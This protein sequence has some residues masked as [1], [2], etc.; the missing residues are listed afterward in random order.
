MILLVLRVER[1]AYVRQAGQ[2]RLHDGQRFGRI[3]R[4][5]RCVIS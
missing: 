5:N 2:Q 3:G 4:V 1:H